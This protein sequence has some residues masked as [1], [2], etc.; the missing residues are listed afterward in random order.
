MECGSDICYNVRE[1]QKHWAK[2]MRPDTKVH[3]LYD[4]VHIKYAE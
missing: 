1:P 2:R 4:S 3:I